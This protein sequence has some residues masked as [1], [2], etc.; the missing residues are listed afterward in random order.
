MTYAESIDWLY[1]TQ[2]FGIKL[3]LDGPKK[4]LATY[5]AFPPAEVT[6]IQIAGTNGKGSTA[7]LLDSIIRSGG[8]T[9][10]LFTSPHL[11]DYRERI[12]ANGRHISEDD[13]SRQLSALKELIADWEHHPTFFELTLALAMRHFR[14]QK[15]GY[16][17][18]E[19]GMGGRLDATTAVPADLSLITPIGLDHTQ[20]LGETLPEIAGEKAGIIREKVPVI[21][22]PQKPEATQ[23]LRQTASEKRAPLCF[24]EEPVTGYYL[25]LPGEHQQWNAALALEAAHQLK[26]PLNSDL[27]RVALKKATHPGR[28]EII[29]RE[30]DLPPLVLDA[31]HNPHAAQT[32]LQTWQEQFGKQKA[33]LVFGAVESKDL[34]SLLDIISPI[35]G[36]IHLVPT[37]SQRGLSP[38]EIAKKLPA[39]LTT[40]PVQ[41]PSLTSALDALKA[42]STPLLITGSIFLLGEAKALLNKKAHRTSTQ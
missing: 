26:L 14:E 20:W 36:E 34:T 33:T 10:G 22:S 5:D 29:E 12:S 41:H 1:S 13:C 18:L 32:L 24:I 37:N 4:L 42:H 6:V 17:I 3:G 31:A 38:E 7:T 8:E 11:I 15:V 25:N 16:I 35:I 19:T 9:C 27:V 30:K 23:V 40:S 28:F 39:S 21:S 2:M